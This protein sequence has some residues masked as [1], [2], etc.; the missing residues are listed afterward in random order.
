MMNYVVVFLLLMSMQVQANSPFSLTKATKLI[1]HDNGQEVLVGFDSS[2]ENGESCVTNSYFVLKREHASFAE[3][4]AALLSAFHSDTEFVGWV[5][6]CHRNMPI[7]TR[8]DLR[9]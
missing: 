3:I 6:G 1:V 2:V 9:R 7:L 5:N 4:Y 8:I